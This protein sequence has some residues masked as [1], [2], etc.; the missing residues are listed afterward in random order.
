MLQY[1][2]F[3]QNNHDMDIVEYIRF[4]FFINQAFDI[5]LHQ[6][7]RLAVLM[8]DLTVVNLDVGF[9]LLFVNIA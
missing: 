8:K 3:P 9:K 5:S 7:F 1:K 6:Y 2:E 4:L